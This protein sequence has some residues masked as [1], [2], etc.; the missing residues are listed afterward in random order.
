M[1]VYHF[2]VYM[3][4]FVFIYITKL[5]QIWLI[6]YKCYVFYEPADVV[7]APSDAAAE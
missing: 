3:S 1:G 7:S 2:Y 5:L 4:N 6:S